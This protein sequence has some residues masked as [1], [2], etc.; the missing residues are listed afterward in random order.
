MGGGNCGPPK[1]NKTT[2]NKIYSA[3]G[4]KLNINGKKN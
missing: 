2:K 3:S 4:T 1:K